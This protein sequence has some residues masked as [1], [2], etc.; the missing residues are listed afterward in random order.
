MTTFTKLLPPEAQP[1]QPLL[2]RAHDLV[3]TSA[4]RYEWPD[5]FQTANG[6]V[7]V[8]V[9]E[10]RPLQIDDVFVD[11]KGE[12]WVVRPPPT[13]IPPMSVPAIPPIPAALATLPRLIP[14]PVFFSLPLV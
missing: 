9:E 2:D 7:E 12:F 13:F 10:R 4:E 6:P 1:A 8:A 5:V 14:R 3:L 11:D